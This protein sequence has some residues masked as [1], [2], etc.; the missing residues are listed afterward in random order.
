MTV[1]DPGRLP[2]APRPRTETPTRCAPVSRT[3]SERARARTRG[4][5]DAVDDADLVAPALAADVAAGLGPRARRQP[6][7]ALAGPRRRRPRAGPAGH[8]RALRRVQARPGRPARAA[9]AHARRRR[10]PTS[11]DVRDKVLDLLDAQPRCADGRWSTDGFAFGMIVQHEQ[12]HDETMLAT[13]QLRAGAAGA[14]RPAAAAS[15][16]RR[17]A[18]P[19]CWCPAGPFTMGTDDRAVGAGQRA[20][21]APRRPARVLDRRRPGHQRRSTRRSSTPAATTT[22]A[23]GARRAGRT[24]IEAGLV[25]PLF[26]AR[27]GDGTWWRRRFG[28]RRAGAGRRAGGARLLLTRR[29]PTRR[30]RASG[31]PPRPSGR[32]RPGATRRP[33]GPGATPGA[34]T[35][36]RPRTP[37]SGSGTCARAGGRL[38]GGRVAAGRAPAHRRRLGVDQLGLAPYPGF[39]AFPYREYSR[40]VLRRR[41]PGAARRLVRHRPGGL[42]RHLPQ[43][44]P[45]DPPADLRRV[46]L[47]PGRGPRTGGGPGAPDVCR[48]LAYLGPPVT[49]AALLLDPPHGLLHQS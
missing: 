18:A 41:L 40:G 5:T 26:W 48:H 4:L 3:S 45:P 30:G 11:R 25:A 33:A 37:T 7:G 35:T 43:L 27:D 2:G 38:P 15:R 34:T 44:G 14:A 28:V 36:R 6:G 22:R 17:R 9:A 32:R 13:H 23:G 16:P 19:R 21:R 20:A 8:R 24:G 12:Q 1:T 46:P 29:R 10:A 31:C 39:A 42:P 49:L 47:R